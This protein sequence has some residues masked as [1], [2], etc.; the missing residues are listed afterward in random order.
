MGQTLKL[1][2][3]L[4]GLLAIIVV[5]FF[6]IDFHYSDA[7]LAPFY[8]D[9]TLHFLGG[10]FVVALATDFLLTNKVKLSRYGFM[11]AVFLVG[12]VALI[13]VLWEFYEY[14]VADIF[15]IRQGSL[16]DVLSDLL[17]DI[18]GGAAFVIFYK[19]DALISNSR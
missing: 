6:Y 7:N 11:N 12:L 5:G 18:L 9:L 2:Y 17:M 13:G 3:F 8:V 14:V 4:V 16:A 15:L 19:L 10:V 1:K